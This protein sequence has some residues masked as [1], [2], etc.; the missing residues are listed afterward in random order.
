[1]LVIRTVSGLPLGFVN[2]ASKRPNRGR[3]LD[4]ENEG[5]EVLDGVDVVGVP[6]EKEP[7]VVEAPPRRVG[8]EELEG[9]V[10]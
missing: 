4:A 6:L 7:L 5:H 8:R 2:T 9:A 3:V 1:M 10:L